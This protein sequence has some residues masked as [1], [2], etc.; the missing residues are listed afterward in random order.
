MRLTA[1]VILRTK[2]IGVQMTQGEDNEPYQEGDTFS[3][4]RHHFVGGM[5]T[6]SL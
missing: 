5:R 1:V 2:I 4:Q 6:S 3:V